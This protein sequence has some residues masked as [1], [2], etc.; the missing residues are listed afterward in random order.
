[1]FSREIGDKTINTIYETSKINNKE[2]LMTLCE[3]LLKVIENNYELEM[4]S[5][6]WEIA[7]DKISKGRPKEIFWIFLPKYESI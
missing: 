3:E 4:P 2:S 5:L 6:A 1:M 7:G